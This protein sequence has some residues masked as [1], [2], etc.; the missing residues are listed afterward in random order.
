MKLALA[1]GVLLAQD[2]KPSAARDA[3]LVRWETSLEE[4]LGK[5]R[6]QKKLVCWYVGSVHRSPMDK[7]WALDN[8]ARLALL[9]DPRVAGVLNGRFIPLRGRAGSEVKVQGIGPLK[10]IEPGFVFLNADGEIVHRAD[11]INTFNVDWMLHLLRSVLQEKEPPED[12]SNDPVDQGLR[13]L[14]TGRFAEARERFE[15]ALK[16]E[17]RRQNEALWYLGACRL[18]LNDERG[19]CEEWGKIRG[20]DPWA[21]KAAAELAGQ[22]PLAYGYESLE[23]PPEEVFRTRPTG[24]EG[25][26]K[27]AVKRGVEWLLR[28]QRSN[29]SWTDSRYDFGGADDLPNVYAAVTA[30][31]ALALW[32]HRDT[33]PER[34]D[35][36][37]EKAEAYLFNEENLARNARDELI[38]AHVYRLYYFAR[39][40]GPRYTD[41]MNEIVASVA[42]LQ[43]GKGQWYHEYPAPFTTASVLCALRL[44]RDAGAN[45]PDDLVRRGLSALKESRD[46]NGIFAYNF[47]RRG[48]AV[49]GGAGRMPLCEMALVAWRESDDAALR[50]AVDAFFAHKAKLDAVRKYDD[51]ADAWGNGGF[52]VW[53]D[54][55]EATRA[56]K[57]L[58]G[59]EAQ[60]KRLLDWTLSVQEFDGSWVDSHELGK[61]Y[62]TA[63]ALLVIRNCR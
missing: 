28:Y 18:L 44:A 53:Y 30:L 6:A 11:R 21:R 52:F 35:R 56:L 50:A 46:K 59:T 14:R 45:V 12:D 47:G 24:T 39:R 9:S 36:A 42:K 55:Y 16:K 17:T 62:G 2:R 15:F 23:R 48:G 40:K 3:E 25:S 43:N 58:S 63:M 33:A 22:G 19:A 41:K 60:R 7:W 26:W 49:E 32:E 1:L 57:L 34:I 10:F 27:D 51:H 4:A 61:S 5:A 29:G 37:I 38:W 54:V 31:A 8:Y 20:D 13:H